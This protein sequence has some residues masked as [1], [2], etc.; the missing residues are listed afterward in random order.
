MVE[1]IVLITDTVKLLSIT[2]ADSAC[3][4]IIL[5]DRLRDADKEKQG[6]N[7]EYFHDNKYFNYPSL[8]QIIDNGNK[9][10]MKFYIYCY[11]KW[12]KKLF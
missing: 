1:T 2:I 12:R 10:K 8:N 4:E 5:T 7:S 11:N 6:C 3:V 9:M